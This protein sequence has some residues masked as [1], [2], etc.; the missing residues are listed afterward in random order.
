[1]M[2]YVDGHLELSVVAASW[3]IECTNLN[4]AWLGGVLGA[5]WDFGV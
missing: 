4:D 3:G 1:M 2:G 5:Y